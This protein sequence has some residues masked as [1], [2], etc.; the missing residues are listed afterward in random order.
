[1][2]RPGV[3]T[4]VVAVVA[5][6]AIITWGIAALSDDRGEP[7]RTPS[8]SLSAE[9]SQTAADSDD[10]TGSIEPSST[11]R[12]LSA[13]AGSPERDAAASGSSQQSGDAAADPSATEAEDPAGP[14]DDPATPVVIPDLTLEQ[15]K[16]CYWDLI[17]A[18][19]RAVAEAEAQYPLDAEPPDVAAHLALRMSLTETYEAAV[20]AEYGITAAELE[21]IGWEGIENNWPMPPLEG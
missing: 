10:D 5:T 19:D 17:A 6:T 4:T 11:V 3:V 12:E 20:R 7:I 9:N 1:M 21:A 13:A 16:A 8:L 14:A 18:Q 2:K 15:R